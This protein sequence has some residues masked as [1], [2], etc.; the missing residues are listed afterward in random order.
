MAFA[1]TGFAA[2]HAGTLV[3][4]EPYRALVSLTHSDGDFPAGLFQ[5]GDLDGITWYYNFS[6]TCL[7]RGSLPA[8]VTKVEDIGDYVWSVEVTPHDFGGGDSGTAWA[9]GIH[10]FSLM[11]LAPGGHQSGTIASVIIPTRGRPTHKL[12]AA[13]RASLLRAARSAHGLADISQ[14]K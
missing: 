3:G 11:L 4:R 9:P 5:T 12:S 1:I 7:T 6:A 2:D 8:I 10:L 13:G 14:R